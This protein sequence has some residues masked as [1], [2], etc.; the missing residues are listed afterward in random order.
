MTNPSLPDPDPETAR[1]ALRRVIDPEVGMNIV[2]LGL[3]Y[4]I[5]AEGDALVVEMTMTSPACPLGDLI[6]EDAEA[7]LRPL[8]AE[9]MRLDLRLVWSPPWEPALMSESAKRHFDW[10]GE[11]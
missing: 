11:E 10:R 5:A 6:L 7:A 1:A 9:G 4:R 8:L 2:D 3:V